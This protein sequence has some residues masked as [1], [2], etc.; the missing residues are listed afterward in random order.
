MSNALTLHRIIVNVTVDLARRAGHADVMREQHDGAIGMRRRA[1]QH[2][3]RL[4]LALS[5]PLP[6]SRGAIFFV[7]RQRCCA[8]TAS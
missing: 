7:T 6:R 4:R 5:R 3:R 1:H 2:P 8:G